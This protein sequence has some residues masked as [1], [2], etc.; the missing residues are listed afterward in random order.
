M[1]RFVGGR[2]DSADG[3]GLG[4]LLRRAFKALCDS[5]FDD[6]GLAQVP[7]CPGLDQGLARRQAEAI[8][9]LAGRNVVQG[10]NHQIEALKVR[11]SEL[12]SLDVGVVSYNLRSG[13]EGLDSLLGHQGL[14]S[15]HVLGTEEELAVQ[16][17]HIDRVE[18]DHL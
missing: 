10:T 4:H 15:V 3:K 9:V 8:H 12:W 5:L 17:R 1:D 6:K 11:N 18:V 2:S 13:V 14:G 7:L 16:V